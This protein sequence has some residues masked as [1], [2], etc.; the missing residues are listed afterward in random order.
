P[1]P[2]STLFAY[3][4]LFRSVLIECG[5]CDYLLREVDMFRWMLEEFWGDLVR[6]LASMAK[7]YDE[8][9]VIL[10]LFV[11]ATLGADCLAD[12]YRC[13]PDRK[14]TRLNS[15]HRTIS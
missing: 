6:S 12:E 15:S 4:T 14:S 13:T 5:R 8:I 7:D 10:L 1:H 11:D 2:T 3:T 9:K